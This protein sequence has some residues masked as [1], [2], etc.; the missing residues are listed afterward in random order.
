MTKRN[1]IALFEALSA[2]PS[3]FELDWSLEHNKAQNIVLLNGPGGAKVI[4]K[5]SAS[6]SSTS[7]LMVGSW[8]NGAR[9]EKMDPYSWGILSIG[10]SYPL[11]RLELSQHTLFLIRS[12]RSFISVYEPIYK[13][14]LTQSRVGIAS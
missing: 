4:I 10:A 5:L 7:G 14:C 13:R 9:G 6:P 3:A 11:A 12:I 8:P 2:V 1:V